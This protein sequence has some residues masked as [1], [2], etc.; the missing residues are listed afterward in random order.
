MVTTKCRVTTNSHFSY[1]DTIF[2]KIF[3]IF[4]AF[5]QKILY[6]CTAKS[7]AR[8]TKMEQKYDFKQIPSGWRYCFH[9]QCPMKDQCLRYQT[10]Q[11]LP[12]SYEMGEAVFPSEEMALITSIAMVRNGSHLSSRLTSEPYSAVQVIKKK[13]FSVKPVWTMTSHKPKKCLLQQTCNAITIGL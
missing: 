10:A 13:W 11:A 8:E 4:L 6:L 5:R 2:L 12:E 1:Y 7:I 9:A 3:A